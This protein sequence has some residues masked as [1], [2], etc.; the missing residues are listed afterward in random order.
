MPEV[1]VVTTIQIDG[2]HRMI[3]SCIAI[4]NCSLR[5]PDDIYDRLQ[6]YL[7]KNYKYKPDVQGSYVYF[8]VNNKSRF[9]RST[10]TRTN[11][12]FYSSAMPIP[13]W[14]MP[15]IVDLSRYTMCQF[16]ENVRWNPAVY[17]N[18]EP[19][20]TNTLFPKFQCFDR[21]QDC[22]IAQDDYCTEVL[23]YQGIL[24]A[25]VDFISYHRYHNG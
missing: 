1:R 24:V 11:N 4:R 2:K 18:A 23:S 10:Y 5:L 13:D 7:F 19:K 8:N 15:Y 22:T 20:I 25:R 21:C 17:A 12:H 3:P 9:M 14:I 16:L 6:N